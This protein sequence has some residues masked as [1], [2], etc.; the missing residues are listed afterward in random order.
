MGRCLLS[1]LSSGHSPPLFHVHGRPWI[2]RTLTASPRLRGH[3]EPPWKTPS[4]TLAPRLVNPTLVVSYQPQHRFL[5]GGFPDAQTTLGAPP[6]ARSP[7]Y[8]SAVGQGLS[9]VLL[10]II[11]PV[12]GTMPDKWLVLNKYF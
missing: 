2:P 6:G 7:H 1:G 10:T 3:G 4:P 9:W 11:S 8:L 5:Q 12:P